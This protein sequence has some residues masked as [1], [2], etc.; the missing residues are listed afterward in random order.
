VEYEYNA[1]VT[2]TNFA[3]KHFFKGKGAGA[4]PT[5]A[6]VLSDLSALRY[7]YTY[8]YKKLK[9]LFSAELTY[10]YYLQVYV[11]A[12]HDARIKYADFAWIEEKHET[13]DHHSITGVIH[14]AK[15]FE[16]DWW[17]EDGVSLI[18]Q[19]N[20]LIEDI[21]YRDI[22]RRSLELAGIALDT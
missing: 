21:S 9:P 15:L 12:S 2:E 8:E 16:D 18:V 3:D 6:A 14:A 7:N 4:Y 10:D 17:K 20:G 19:P 11:S 1:L 13:Q 5:A 22:G